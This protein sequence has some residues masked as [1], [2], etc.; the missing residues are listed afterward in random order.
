M[1]EAF[2]AS[3]PEWLRMA[4]AGS[5]A[6]FA[7]AFAIYHGIRHHR[8]DFFDKRHLIP[9]FAGALVSCALMAVTEWIDVRRHES[10]AE[11][12]GMTLVRTDET[13]QR[14]QNADSTHTAEFK[15]LRHGMEDVLSTSVIMVLPSTVVWI[16]TRTI[17]RAVRSRRGSVTEALIESRVG[18][19]L[20]S[21]R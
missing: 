7:L 9:V 4:I 19:P 1:K 3:V 17:T 10:W 2:M 11:S 13:S 14:W 6:L 5:A 12:Q 20:E 16:V 15:S 8:V 21:P 18:P